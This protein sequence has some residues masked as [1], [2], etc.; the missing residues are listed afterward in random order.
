M[1]NYIDC[2][3]VHCD[4]GDLVLNLESTNDS[5]LHLEQLLDTVKAHAYVDY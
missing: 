4:N 1:C 5:H 2:H 3:I